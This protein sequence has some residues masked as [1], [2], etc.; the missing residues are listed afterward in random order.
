[1]RR[2]IR[3]YGRYVAAIVFFA[4]LSVVCGVYILSQQHLRTPFQD[5]YTVKVQMPTSQ[6]LTSGKN[7]PVNVAGVRVGDVVK[8]EL[9]DG[10]SMVTLSVDKHKLPAVFSDRRGAASPQHALK[11]MQIELFPGHRASGK[12]RD[13]SGTIRVEKTLVP[14]DSDEF[15]AALDADTRRLLP[16]PGRGLRARPGG[17]GPRP[18]GSAARLGPT[19]TQLHQLGDALAARRTEMRRLVHNLAV[20]SHATAAKD[21]ELGTAVEAGATTLRAI[22]GQDAALRDSIAQLPGT[23]SA[24]RSTLGHATTLADEV[25]P[26]LNS[27]S[28]AARR[29][30]G[31]LR[32]VDPLLKVTEPLVR[33]KL[34]PLV[35]GR[36]AGDRRPQPGHRQ[37]QQDLAPSQDRLRG[38]RLRGQRAGLQPGGQGGGLPVLAGLVRPQRQLRAV[39]TGRP[40]V[41][42]PRAR[43]RLLLQ[44]HVPAAAWPRCCRRS[45]GWCRHAHE[46]EVVN[47]RPPRTRGDHG[48]GPVRAVVLRRHAVRL[49]V[50]RR[51]EPTSAAG[52]R[53]HASFDQAATLS[54]NADVRISGVSVGKV[55]KVTPE[56]LRTD[57]VIQLE[58]QYARPSPATRGRF[59]APRRC[60]ARPSSSSPTERGRRRS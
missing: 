40:R 21:R 1:M 16:G 9:Q 23:L 20:L 24:A 36:R 59:C 48:R 37:P 14:V 12:L 34:R 13:W 52:Y 7:Q 5:R 29:L 51:A 11:Y 26:T 2:A 56:G 28:P 33:T 54:P 38:L 50:V 10:R 57:A 42:D 35:E 58:G 49:A 60:W 8:T 25:G 4:A 43:A 39:D 19:T 6:S 18:A 53:F 3:E 47:A 45:P 22:A 31:A 27:L 15:L 32:D 46:E 44:R 30:P 55:I 41:G 17:P